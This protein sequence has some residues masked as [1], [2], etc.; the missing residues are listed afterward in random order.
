MRTTIPLLRK[1]VRKVISESMDR[2]VGRVRNGRRLISVDGQVVAYIEKLTASTGE[3]I[4]YGIFL[5]DGSLS[6]ALTLSPV[7]FPDDIQEEIEQIGA[8]AKYHIEGFRHEREALS[9]AKMS[10]KSS[11]ISL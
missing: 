2:Q 11:G 3:C 4:G 10:A 7:G 9:T 5:E 8:S 6:R 1:M